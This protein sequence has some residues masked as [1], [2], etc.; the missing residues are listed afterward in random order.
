MT[1]TR[2][3]LLLASLSTAPACVVGPEVRQESCDQ[4]RSLGIS[5]DGHAPPSGVYK[6]YFKARPRWPYLAYCDMDSGETYLPLPRMGDTN[7]SELSTPAGTLRTSFKML[8]IDPLLMFVDVTDRRFASSTWTPVWDGPAPEV[9]DL[10]YG[11]AIST[12]G[13]RDARANVDL[14]GTHLVID[15]LFS[16]QGPI[17]AYTGQVADIVVGDH[18]WLSATA[19]PDHTYEARDRNFQLGYDQCP[20]GDCTEEEIVV[21]A[22]EA[23]G[24][25]LVDSTESAP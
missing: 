9:T 6:I 14:R 13:A 20:A 8:K 10:P 24:V 7:F 3:L 1:N 12:E 19:E 22:A 11:V 16:G 5:I 18:Q 21:S 25:E 4:V 23:A 2:R 15:Q 17:G